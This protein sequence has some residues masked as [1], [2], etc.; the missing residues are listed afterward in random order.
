MTSIPRRSAMKQA[1]GLVGT[2]ALLT[3]GGTT[4]LTTPATAADKDRYRKKAEALRAEQKDIHSHRAS[5]NGWEM[6]RSVNSG[7][8]IW[9]RPVPGTRAEIDV[10][11]GS[12][13]FILVH[14][15]QRFHYE[16]REL[17]ADD[18]TGWCSPGK[19]RKGLPE[20][21]RASGTAVTILPGHYPPGT[22]GG[23]HPHETAVLRDI[24]AELDGTVRWGGDDRK[25]DESLFY[26]DAQPEDARLGRMESQLKGWRK[27]PGAGP[28]S[29]V[30]IRSSGRR[31]K[32]DKIKARQAA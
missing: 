5:T 12:V 23:F 9:T 8:H 1:L 14:L 17:G 18:V 22:T 29:A 16:I 25:P 26:L 27:T 13:E 6:Q 4:L 11:I 10:R 15:V 19:V 21:N 24:L 28:G 7:G 31:A 32:A 30:D 20:S 3:V 2:G